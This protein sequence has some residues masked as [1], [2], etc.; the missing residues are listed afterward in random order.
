MATG[1]VPSIMN[2]KEESGWFA[3]ALGA[4]FETAM[5]V[6]GGIAGSALGPEGAVLGASLGS[7]ASKG[8]TGE[9]YLGPQVAGAIGAVGS[10]KV[11]DKIVNPFTSPDKDTGFGKL[12]SMFSDEDEAAKLAE[13]QAANAAAQ[14]MT[15]QGSVPV[16]RR[17][18]G[19]V[20]EKTVLDPMNAYDSMLQSNT[21]D[22]LTGTD[23]EGTPFDFTSGLGGE[24]SLYDRLGQNFAPQTV[25]MPQRQTGSLVVP[26]APLSLLD[27]GRNMSNYSY[28]PQGF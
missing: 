18:T 7:K 19:L 28:I 23:G 6:G 16:S 2:V 12:V 10:M 24:G 27:R 22:T 26:D 20:P 1:G 17:S 8:I 14:N 13:A 15:L 3:D 25:G 11:P 21:M 4:L 5:T 9:S